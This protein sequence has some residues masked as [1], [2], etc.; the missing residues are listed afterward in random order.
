MPVSGSRDRAGAHRFATENQ[1]AALGSLTSVERLICTRLIDRQ[2][3][4]GGRTERDLAKYGLDGTVKLCS[5]RA[6]Q[7]YV[8]VVALVGVVLAVTG[9]IQAAVAVLIVLRMIFLMFLAR[10]VSAARTGRRWRRGIGP[11]RSG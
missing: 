5:A 6:M 8:Y 2:L 3:F 11:A 7:A 1:A 10:C 4:H 9:A